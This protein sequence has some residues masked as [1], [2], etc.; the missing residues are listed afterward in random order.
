MKHIYLLLVGMIFSLLFIPEFSPIYPATAETNNSVSGANYSRALQPWKGD[1]D[2]MLERRLLRIAVPYS[3]TD[4]F[5][6]GASERGVAAAMGRQLEEEINR[7]E[8]LRSRRLHVVFIPAPRNRL[9]DYVVSGRADVAMGGIT[10]TDSRRDKVTFTSPFIRN[11]EELLVSGPGAPQIESV[12]DLAGQTIHVQ[13]SSSYYAALQKLNQVFEKQGLLPMLIEPV[14]ELLE[15]DEILELAQ[16]GQIQLTISDR[17][18]A[19][20]WERVFPDLEV[21]TDIV[22]AAERNIAWAFRNDSPKLEAVLNDFLRS[23][24]P[25]TAFGNIV[26]QRYMQSVRWVHNTNTSINR[27][28]FEEIIPLFR[29]FGER[30][31]VDPLLLAALGYQESRLNQATRSPAGAIGVMQLLPATGAS[32][33]VGDITE[34]EPN[35]HAGTK[36][37]SQLRDRQVATK[38]MDQLNT[39]FMALA[40]YNA[41]QTRI[42]RL[43]QAAAQQGLDPNTWHGNVELLAAREIGR[44]TVQY[45]DNIYKYYLSYR[46]VEKQRAKR[47]TRSDKQTN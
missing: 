43:R 21:R 16:A 15:P 31:D 40:S 26:L 12:T 47:A 13:Q 3:M 32:L 20:F 37:F 46:R 22:I 36:Y 19:E 24:R 7:E 28:R 4:Y 44:E 34:L 29:K 27:A 17:H 2:G 11:S 41:G 10:V 8:G 23:H 18:L 30:Y 6:D 45:V 35:I 1:Y 14:D 9:L 5:L 39:M 33:G 42:R 25:R 38:G